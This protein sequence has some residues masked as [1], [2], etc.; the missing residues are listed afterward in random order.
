MRHHQ[1]APNRLA[2]TS[3][4]LRGI[5][6]VSGVVLA[7]CANHPEYYR[8]DLTGVESA[9]RVALLPLVNM[10]HDER[11]PDLVQNALVVEFLAAGRFV[12]VDPGV[13]EQTVL[14]NRLRLTD[15]LPLETLQKLGAALGVDY[16][17][18]GSVNEFAMVQDGI[19]IV[20][21]VSVTVRMVSCA[22]GAIMWAATHSRRGDDDE[23]VFQIGRIDTLEELSAVTA[24]EIADTFG[25]QPGKQAGQP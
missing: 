9:S 20:P 11:A 24:R 6:L 23:S 4:R 2:R 21:T 15:R 16:L 18:V 25:P 7:G 3:A 10:S 5:L 12:V 17:I 19:E 1:H 8:G 22:T 13:V 14:E